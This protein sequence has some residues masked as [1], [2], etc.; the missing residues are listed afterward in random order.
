MLQKGSIGEKAVQWPIKSCCESVNIRF[1]PTF[2]PKIENQSAYEIIM[3]NQLT[4]PLQATQM[5]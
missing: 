2:L 4:I 1:L 5:L 3:L